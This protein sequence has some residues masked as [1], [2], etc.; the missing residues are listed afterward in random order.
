MSPVI[1]LMIMTAF[2]E[3]LEATWTNANIPKPQFHRGDMTNI[4]AGAKLTGHNIKR[5]YRNSSSFNTYHILYLDDGSFIFQSREDLVN[6]LEIINN[7][8]ETMGLEMHVGKG[9]TK[10][11]T[12][13]MYFPTSAFFKQHT[14]APIMNSTEPTVIMHNPAD[15]THD[16]EGNNIDHTTYSKLSQKQRD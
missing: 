10:S 11:K 9:E 4:Q 15:D 12:E 5:D 7:I 3:I 14:P 2:S 13:A 16:R 6:G 1:F 8:F